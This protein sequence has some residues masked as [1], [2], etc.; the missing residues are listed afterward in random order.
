MFQLNVLTGGKAGAVCV[1]RHFPFRIGRVPSMD[2]CLEDEGVWDR[3][4]V[5]DLTPENQVLLTVPS[6]AT[7]TVNSEP[8]RQSRLRNGDV[9]A[10]GSVKLQFWLSETRPISLRH[11]EWLTWA[12]L[13]ALS[14]GQVALVYWLLP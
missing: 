7:A 4:L 13:A 5:L 11:R 10:I 3:H 9:L 1:A 12:A 6:E 2:L 14:L 8:F